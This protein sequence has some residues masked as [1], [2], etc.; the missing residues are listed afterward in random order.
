[1]QTPLFF[2]RRLLGLHLG[3]DLQSGIPLNFAQHPGSVLKCFVLQKPDRRKQHCNQ[4]KRHQIGKERCAKSQGDHETP[5]LHDRSAIT[6][7]GRHQ[8]FR[9][10]SLEFLAR[11]L[12]ERLFDKKTHIIHGVVAEFT[13][14]GQRFFN[15]LIVFVF[16]QPAVPL[17]VLP[18]VAIVAVFLGD[19]AMNGELFFRG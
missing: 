5:L 1:M 17:L 12:L 2:N 4:Y 14:M 15:H 11:R 18:I 8:P 7:F 3:F 16:S 13:D 6:F 10:Q 9:Q 19:A